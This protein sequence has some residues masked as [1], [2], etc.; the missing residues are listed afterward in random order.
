[1]LLSADPQGYARQL[2]DYLK[3]YPDRFAPVESAEHLLELEQRLASSLPDVVTVD[4]ALPGLQEPSEAGRLVRWYRRL[5]RERGAP[6]RRVVVVSPVGDDGLVAEAF[7]WG[8]DYFVVRP[9]DLA[10]F[11]RRL[12]QLA[13][14]ERPAG[15]G[16]RA[17]RRRELEARVVAYLEAL[18]VPAHYKG[19]AYLKDAVVMVAERRN[20]LE[21][22]TKELYPHIAALHRTSAA[23]VERAMRHAIESTVQ[24]G[25]LTLIERLFASL[26]DERRTRPTNSS[27][28]A[29][30]ADQVRLEM[31]LDRPR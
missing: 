15:G 31:E 8:A 3:C 1:M 22:V 23:K 28:I 17:R 7:R 9:L 4:L 16:R 11:G 12:Q 29:R 19:R 5:S 10:T 18:G 24:R 14:G 27:F 30:L 25:N 2:A 20:L 13:S 6:A 21:R 26:M